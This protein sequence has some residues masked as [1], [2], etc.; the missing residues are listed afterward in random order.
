MRTVRRSPVTILLLTVCLTACTV[1]PAPRYP[2]PALLRAPPPVAMPKLVELAHHDNGRSKGIL[3]GEG[4][5]V[6]FEIRR[7]AS[8]PNP[9]G[10]SDPIGTPNPI[11]PARP[12][13]LL[14]PILA[15]GSELM[16]L[17]AQRLAAHGFDVAFCKR[18]GRALSPPQRG[19]ELDELFRRTV[20]H[21]RLLLKWLRDAN[22][23]PPSLHV[24]GIS[25]GGIISTVLAAIDQDLR[26]AAICLAGADL[27]NLMLFSSESRV[28]KWLTWRQETDGIGLDS[29]HWELS[30]S[31]SHEP[32]RYAASVPT[33]KVL[34][35]SAALDTVVP[36]RNQSLLWEGLGRPERL[37]VPFGHYTA[38]VALDRVI[39]AAADHFHAHCH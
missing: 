12:M 30:Q 10:I 20:L 8:T 38:A 1:Q 3:V 2:R 26:S 27:A 15:G 39:G 21:Q 14:V 23:P 4:E 33:E 32:A 29:L 35:V 19:P 17:V 28:Q 37:D 5:Q 18:A 16:G 31:L 25:M 22:R 7:A 9:A 11:G 36:R 13:V 24:L 6:Q 34:F